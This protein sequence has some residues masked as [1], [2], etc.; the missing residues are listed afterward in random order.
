MTAAQVHACACL[1]QA[2]DL[3][4]TYAPL[5]M[6]RAAQRRRRAMEQAYA[7]IRLYGNK[8][9]LDVPQLSLFY[10]ASDYLHKAGRVA[11]QLTKLQRGGRAQ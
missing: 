9:N 1:K 4:E 2:L 8:L 10:D 6:K 5:E 3:I 7:V 11:E